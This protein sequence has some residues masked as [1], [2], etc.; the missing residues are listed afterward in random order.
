MK[1]DQI[2]STNTKGQLV[3]P[4]HFRSTLK[5]D[6][7]TPLQIS[8]IGNSI[9]IIPIIDVV[10]KSQTEDLFLDIIKQSQGAWR[11]EKVDKKT[12]T[13]RRNA[14]LSDVERLRQW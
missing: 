2:V 14:E 5:I 3:I 1:I 4:K 6:P 8:L 13:A 9:R 12:Q 10:T 11:D 7:S